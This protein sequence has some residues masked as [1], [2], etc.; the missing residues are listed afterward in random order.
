MLPHPFELAP[1][2][3]H[4][5]REKYR[6]SGSPELAADETVADTWRRVAQAAAQTEAGDAAVRAQWA[7]RFEEA[8]R[9]F[10]FLPGGR[11]LAGAGTGRR[12]T[13]F[14]CFVLGSIPD[15]LGG[16]FE[17]VREAAVTMQQGGG[18]GHDF[19][20]LRPQG[21]ELKATGATASGPVSFMEVWDGMCRTVMSAGFRR[22]AMMATMRCD[23]PDIELFI[24]AKRAAGRLT[25]F[26]LS[27]LVTDAFMRAVRSDAP[28][29]LVF[30]Q[31]TIATVQARQ[32]WD[33]IMRSTYD[34]AEPGVIFI[35]RVNALNN[36]NY[37]ET[38]HATNPCGEQPLPPYGAC[39]L[40][41][42]NL[43]RLIGAPFSSDARLDLRRLEAHT[44]LA[45]RMLDN[46]IDV[47]GYPLEAQR[48][49]AVAKRRIG[50]GITGL[51]NAL[52]MCGARYGTQQA[53]ELTDTWLR[54]LKV[55]A[56]QA[57]ADLAGE[58][59]AFPAF[60]AEAMLAGRNLA[61][62]PSELRDKIARTGLRN[63]CLTTIAPTGTISLLAGNVSS[64]IEPTFAR[65]YQRR[66][67]SPDGS[68]TEAV[69]EDYAVALHRKLTGREL[70]E[71]E[72]PD[73]HGLAPGD[74]IAMQTAAQRH[75]D[76]AI[77]K[78]VNC[79]ETIGFDAFKS[80]Y[81]DAYDAGLK[82]CTT[83]RPNATTGSVLSAPAET[84]T[85]AADE[86][87]FEARPTPAINLPAS[88]NDKVVYLH[89]DATRP[90]V[91][92]GLTY[93]CSVAGQSEPL[94]I[95]INDR[96]FQGRRRTH[97]MFI[98]TDR[99]ADQVWLAGLARVA[100]ELLARDGHAGSVAQLLKQPHHPQTDATFRNRVDAILNTIAEVLERHET[101][102]APDCGRF[103]MR[104]AQP[105][106]DAASTSTEAD[107]CP[108]CGAAAK[109]RFDG[110][111]V[112]R[113]CGTA[114]CG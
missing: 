79:P 82:G 103:D 71:H 73:V 19:S 51:A 18:I 81:A 50:L 80:I 105:G 83:Y 95:T 84:A 110:C 16:I 69:V 63:G 98:A 40:G 8:M 99:S 70:P 23:H 102:E 112:C 65:Q 30:D 114:A 88:T 52:A 74:H 47:S 89:D 107:V 32:L 46:V 38:I 61:D 55:A 111:W 20:T 104:V 49:E 76:S 90:D 1:I 21:A 15:D 101:R 5:W 42:I 33:R 59:G 37:C 45:V 86:Q 24:D 6:L 97:E 17:A 26:N 35:D 39:L 9:S 92:S 11:I 96:T 91:L 57:S 28:W 72:L 75:I 29:D 77:S 67:L 66:M 106:R 113:S 54:T 100:S 44:R 36:L 48:E 43:A 56:Y 10:V 78:T 94:F 68:H 41:A 53:A 64:G 62:L 12:V 27:V 60:E 22:G 109:I 2:A 87:D 13:L 7:S 25:N 14:N 3:E 4:V 31:K 34:H 85:R 108:S 93:R 58:K